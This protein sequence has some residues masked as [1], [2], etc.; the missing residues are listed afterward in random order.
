[1]GLLS[2]AYSLSYGTGFTSEHELT[3][4]NIIAVPAR[5]LARPLQE[6]ECASVVERLKKAMSY[7]ALMVHVGAG[8]IDARRI[9]LAVDLTDRFHAL[10]I[11]I[12]GRSYLPPFLAE[13]RAADVER[14]DGEW[15]ETMDALADMGKKFRAS[16][17]QMRNVEWRGIPDDANSIV[18]REARAADLVIIGRKQDPRDLYYSLDPDHSAG[19]A[20]GPVRAG[21]DRF[22]RSPPHCGGLEGYSGSPARRSRCASVLEGGEG[23]YNCDGLRT[24]Y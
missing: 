13:D 14:D 20:P 23:G 15:K 5:I 2:A 1:L 6:G 24:R 12:A 17:K 9:R 7:A 4:L 3:Y 11:G 22:A 21:R 8:Q 18:A 19:R 10:L 16:T